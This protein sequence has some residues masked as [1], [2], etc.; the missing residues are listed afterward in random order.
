MLNSLFSNLDDLVN[1]NYLKGL[2]DYTGPN[3]VNAANN[4]SIQ[5][6]VQISAFQS[7][8]VTNFNSIVGDYGMTE[9]W[10]PQRGAVVNYTN[11][12]FKAK[13]LEAAFTG[14]TLTGQS[15][16]VN[17]NGLYI[18]L[19]DSNTQYFD[20]H[21]FANIWDTRGVCIDTT[22]GATWI[23]TTL[24]QGSVSDPPNGNMVTCGWQE[25]GPYG[26]AGTP[27]N[28]VMIPTITAHTQTCI[29]SQ[30]AGMP[31]TQVA[32]LCSPFGMQ[33]TN[34]VATPNGWSYDTLV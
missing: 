13:L 32:S 1:S 11:G 16:P 18:V 28:F 4:I 6:E 8:S 2:Q 22:Q 31:G 30:V 7:G 14:Q 21:T 5:G 17:P 12:N 10:G 27:L 34:L 15:L 29:V 3:G 9:V 19:L 26:Y 23:S 24:E 25:F 33:G 20:Y